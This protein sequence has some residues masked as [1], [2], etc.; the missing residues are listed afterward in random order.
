MPRPIGVTLLAILVLAAS[1]LY[2][3]LGVLLALGWAPVPPQIQLPPEA[4]EVLPI[5]L[6][7]AGALGLAVGLGLWY[8]MRWARIVAIIVVGL[9][10]LAAIFGVGSAVSSGTPGQI[11]WSFVSLG[12]RCLIL[13]YLLQPHVKQAFSGRPVEAAAP[14]P[15]MG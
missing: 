13:W 7:I 5:A 12:I 9:G 10:V 8:L 15:P 4:Q 1:A 3:L 14:L 2:L 6:L 11:A